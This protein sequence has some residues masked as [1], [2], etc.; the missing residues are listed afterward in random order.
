MHLAATA[1]NLKKLL[2]FI[3]TKVETTVGVMF[4][5]LALK[6]VVLWFFRPCLTPQTAPN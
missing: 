1:Y 2:K 3:T 5:E 6:T 4:P